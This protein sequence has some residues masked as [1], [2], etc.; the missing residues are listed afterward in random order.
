VDTQI[1]VDPVD[2]RTRCA[3]LTSTSVDKGPERIYFA[4][5]EDG[6]A[7]W[8]PRAEVSRAPSGVAHAFPALAAGAP[9]DLRISWMDARIAIDDRGDSQLIWGEGLDVLRL[10]APPIHLG[11]DGLDPPLPCA[12]PDTGDDA[13]ALRYRGLVER[14]PVGL[15][16]GAT[17]GGGGDEAKERR[18]LAAGAE[19]EAGRPLSVRSEARD[20][21]FWA[22]PWPEASACDSPD[23]LPL[24]L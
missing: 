19:D 4:R 9:G 8:S 23:T 24:E 13:K 6:G 2:G 20:R 21:K 18:R 1:E 22:T 7:T 10:S 17:V 12:M 15:G 11:G 3:A 14:R 16:P 5:S